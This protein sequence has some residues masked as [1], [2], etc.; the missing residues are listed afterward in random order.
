[1]KKDI[2]YSIWC[3][4]PTESLDDK[5]YNGWCHCA[6]FSDINECFKEKERFW[7]DYDKTTYEVKEYT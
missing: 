2:L 1:M 4:T 5:D 6:I 3:S 7:R